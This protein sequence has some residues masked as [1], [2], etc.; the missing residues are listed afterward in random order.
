M[1]D[2]AY[3]EGSGRPE[4]TDL[5]LKVTYHEVKSFA[6]EMEATYLVKMGCGEADGGV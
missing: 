5:W 3:R 6:V 2:P 4:I 1:C